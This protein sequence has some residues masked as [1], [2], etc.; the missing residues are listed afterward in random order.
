MHGGR[1]LG[2]TGDVSSRAGGAPTQGGVLSAPFSPASHREHACRDAPAS[3][4]AR[5]PRVTAQSSGQQSPCLP[6]D[7][8]GCRGG[9]TRD[10][11]PRDFGPP[12]CSQDG[13]RALRLAGPGGSWAFSLPPASLSGHRTKA[14]EG[15]SFSRGLRLR[16]DASSPSPTCLHSPWRPAGRAGLPHAQRT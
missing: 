4:T 3:G 6:G 9:V 10:A 13:P 1:W 12:G 11:P 15:I 7:H 16:R 5:S 14:K 2:W 8:L